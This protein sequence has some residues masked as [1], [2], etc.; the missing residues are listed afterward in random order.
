MALE[1][2]SFRS[3]LGNV[4]QRRA[5]VV[6]PVLIKLNHRFLKR[7]HEDTRIKLARVGFDL[8]ESLA[9]VGIW[10]AGNYWEQSLLDEFQRPLVALIK[11][12]PI[13]F[14]LL[15]ASHRRPGGLLCT[16]LRGF[17]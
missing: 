7:T 3:R 8:D 15:R 16:F 6:Y 13:E 1:G 4:D 5:P 10:L 12:P 2:V 11:K 17:C 9:Q 14:I